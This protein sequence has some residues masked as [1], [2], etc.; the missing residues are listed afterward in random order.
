MPISAE[1]ERCACPSLR[2]QT[3]EKLERAVSGKNLDF[4][5]LEP[6]TLKTSRRVR[7]L[8]GL[9]CHDEG[10]ESSQTTVPRHATLSRQSDYVWRITELA[11]IALG[12][13]LWLLGLESWPGVAVALLAGSWGARFIWAA[14]N[15][16]ELERGRVVSKVE[17]LT[18]RGAHR[19]L[20]VDV[21]VVARGNDP[22]CFFLVRYARLDPDRTG[23][24]H[25]RKGESR[26]LAC[27]V[28]WGQ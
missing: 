26:S 13:A 27:R 4:S 3:S 17:R 15:V 7:V 22:G 12:F 24:I 1:F 28:S 23:F 20:T 11:L 2:L 6:E 21:P 19:A 5:F 8:T 25:G 14:K 16:N 10:M 18:T 9:L